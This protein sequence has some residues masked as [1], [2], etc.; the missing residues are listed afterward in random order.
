MTCRATINQT[1]LWVCAWC[2]GLLPPDQRAVEPITYGV[3]DWHREELRQR[4]Q[5]IICTRAAER[6]AGER[7]G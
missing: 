5:R 1:P 6:W 2:D 7:R 4:L 3:C